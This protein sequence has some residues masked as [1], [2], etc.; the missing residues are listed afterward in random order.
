MQRMCRIVESADQKRRESIREKQTTYMKTPDRTI[1]QATISNVYLADL[2]NLLSIYGN[3]PLTADFGL[4]LALAAYGAE[5]IGYAYVAFGP[6]GKPQ[7]QALFAPGLETEA[8]KRQLLAHAHQ[9]FDAVYAADGPGFPSLKG[10]IEDLTEW[11]NLRNKPH[12]RAAYP[13]H[14]AQKRAF[15]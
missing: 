8:T 11:L 5:T 1:A 14:Q 3:R 10:H 2:H 9:V 12:A 15:A 4:P 13:K 6:S 7:F